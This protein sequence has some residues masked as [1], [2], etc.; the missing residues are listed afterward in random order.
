MRMGSRAGWRG[1]DTPLASARPVNSRIYRLRSCMER[2]AATGL[3]ICTALRKWTNLDVTIGTIVNEVFEIWRFLHGP[4]GSRY[5]VQVVDPMGASSFWRPLG[6]WWAPC[7]TRAGSSRVREL[8]PG[9]RLCAGAAREGRNIPDLRECRMA[10]YD[11]VTF[12]RRKCAAI[13][14]PR[15][16]GALNPLG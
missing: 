15:G 14:V 12:E 4:R 6:R 2:P 1:R 7:A 13:R 5:R 16:G 9:C 8:C 10:R 3:K 11:A